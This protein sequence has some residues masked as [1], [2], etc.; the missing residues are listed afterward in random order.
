MWYSVALGPRYSWMSVNVGLVT[1]SSEAAWNACAMPFTRVVF[2]APRSPR[3]STSLGALSN[4][5]SSRPS[6]MVSSGEEVVNSRIV[7]ILAKRQYSRSRRSEAPAIPGVGLELCCPIIREAQEG[8]VIRRFDQFVEHTM[9]IVIE[10]N[11]A[12]R[13]K[14]CVGAATH[15]LEYFCHA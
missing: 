6:A 2:P 14:Y 8:A 1:S 5:A 9:V 7:P 12:K 13:L 15:W 10:R 4:D 11:E 3:S